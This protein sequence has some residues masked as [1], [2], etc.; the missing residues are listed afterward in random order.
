MKT[1]EV[2]VLKKSSTT[3]K[4]SIFL[5]ISLTSVRFI[6]I[7][8]DTE[9]PDAVSEVIVQ[10]S[11]HSNPEQL[12]LLKQI[13]QGQTR[14]NSELISR[15]EALTKALTANIDPQHRNPQ[16]ESGSKGKLPG[17]M[18]RAIMMNI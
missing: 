15:L 2:E 3:K 14:Q 8:M 4:G 5:Y 18:T 6:L 16:S 12:E 13:Q 7:N 9:P 1:L 11:N 17:L 10:N